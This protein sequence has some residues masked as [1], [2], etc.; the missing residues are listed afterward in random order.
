LFVDL[1]LFLLLLLLLDAFKFDG[2]LFVL[3]M[4]TGLLVLLDVLFAVRKIYFAIIAP[5][6]ACHALL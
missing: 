1:F 2:P 4:E 3:Q 5:F 6:F